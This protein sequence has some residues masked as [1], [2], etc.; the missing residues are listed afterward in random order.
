[1]TV[2]DLYVS[3]SGNAPG[4]AGGYIVNRVRELKL[5]R[6]LHTPI[7]A[8]CD[9]DGGDSDEARYFLPLV[10]D[11]VFGGIP[12]DRTVIKPSKDNVS[13]ELL[14]FRRPLLQ[15]FKRGRQNLPRRVGRARVRACAGALFEGVHPFSER[16]PRRD[17]RRGRDSPAQ[18]AA[19]RAAPD[20]GGLSSGDSRRPGGLVLVRSAL[21]L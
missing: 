6:A 9:N 14:A 20:G 11:V 10:E 4:L 12:T 2:F 21:P 13:P 8:L 19:L 1:V 5:A 15:R 18:P 17:P 7:L 3:Q 16:G